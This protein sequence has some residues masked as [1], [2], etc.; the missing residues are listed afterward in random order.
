MT[1]HRYRVIASGLGFFPS[2]RKKHLA[3]Y[4]VDW[5]L[6]SLFKDQVPFARIRLAC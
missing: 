1:D 3:R 4:L 5:L 6:E 2:S